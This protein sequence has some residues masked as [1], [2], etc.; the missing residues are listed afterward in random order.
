MK[1]NDLMDPNMPRFK[2]GVK[3]K[4]CADHIIRSTIDGQNGGKPTFTVV[5]RGYC[6]KKT[7]HGLKK[8]FPQYKIKVFKTAEGTLMQFI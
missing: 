3:R 2:L 4:P 7:A 5:T 1:Q 8:H 6:S